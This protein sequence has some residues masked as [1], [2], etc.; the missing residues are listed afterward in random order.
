MTTEAAA[1]GVRFAPSAQERFYTGSGKPMPFPTD[2]YIA[3]AI[4]KALV[5]A[6]GN[7]T[8]DTA[9]AQAALLTAA[10]SVRSLFPVNTIKDTD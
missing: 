2:G 7:N 1:E 10:R 9:E 6:V 4:W 5:P 8:F 3:V